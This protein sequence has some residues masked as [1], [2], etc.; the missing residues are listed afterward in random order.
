MDLVNEPGDLAMQGPRKVGRL[1]PH[2]H[3]G[4]YYSDVTGRPIVGIPKTF[5]FLVN[6]PELCFCFGCA[7]LIDPQP[8]HE[9]VLVK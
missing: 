3:C 6:L 8:D 5:N 9:V 1:S 2:H 7:K 4:E